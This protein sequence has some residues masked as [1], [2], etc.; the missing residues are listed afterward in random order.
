M[1]L[2]GF[3]HE[4]TIGKL[5][6]PGLVKQ[7]LSFPGGQALP[8]ELRID[9]VRSDL[10]RVKRPPHLTESVVVIPSTLRARP[11]ARCQRSR[12]V[13][14]EQL[15]EPPGRHQRRAPPAAEA[16]PTGDPALGGVGPSD[17]A[18]L[19]VQAPA[20]AVHEPSFR[21]GD[22]LAQRRDAIA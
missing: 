13:E 7:A 2:A 9:R 8:V 12:L 16:Q 22:Q 4:R 21:R 1:W 10:A 20:V 14:E 3:E 6:I 19:I 15:G 5:A 17:L 18:L 11:V